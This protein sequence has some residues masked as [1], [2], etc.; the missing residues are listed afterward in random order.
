MSKMQ[1]YSFGTDLK[2]SATRQT[3]KAHGVHGCNMYSWA[4][5]WV[6]TSQ[7]LCF[8]VWNPHCQ[9]EL[10]CKIIYSSFRRVSW[11]APFLPPNVF[12]LSDF[13]WLCCKYTE[14]YGVS[15]LV[16]KWPMGVTVFPPLQ[17]KLLVKNISSLVK[18]NYFCCVLFPST[19]P[20][21]TLFQLDL[22]YPR[23]MDAAMVVG[24]GYLFIACFSACLLHS[25]YLICYIRSNQ[26]LVFSPSLKV[27]AHMIK[28]VCSLVQFTLGRGGVCSGRST[29]SAGVR[30]LGWAKLARSKPSLCSAVCLCPERGNQSLCCCESRDCSCNQ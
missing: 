18:S 8:P 6:N 7:L 25:W 22:F 19:L 24:V 2:G 12:S 17:I 9:Q 13:Y 10:N 3:C 26:V 30:G 5:L 4:F 27:T 1:C 23:L 11:L 15:F 14:Y 28:Q 29:P 21:H 16:Q 20:L